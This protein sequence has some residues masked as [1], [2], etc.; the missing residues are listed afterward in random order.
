MLRKI[1]LFLIEALVAINPVGMIKNAFK[2]KAI[3][4]I[5]EL[6]DEMQ[7]KVKLA[8]EEKGPDAIDA[9]FDECQ[10]KAIDRIQSL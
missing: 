4:V 1:M 7:K 3:K 5:Q 10:K 6:G 8:L 2:R 9:V